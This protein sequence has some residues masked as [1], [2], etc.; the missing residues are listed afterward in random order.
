VTLY[1]GQPWEKPAWH[2]AKAASSE[3]LIV[4]YQ[5][6]VVMP[7]ALGLLS[8][9]H[10]SWE[11]ATPDVALCLGETTKAMIA[12][13][14]EPSGAK[15]V[16]FGSF[17]ARPGRGERRAPRPGL[18][19]VL[20][21]PEGIRSEAK[22]IFDFVTR[23]AELLPEHR[24]IFRCHP[25]LPFDR[26]RPLLDTSPERYTNIEVSTRDA[27]TEDFDRSSVVLYRGSSAVLYA[28]LHGLKPVYLQS[29]G[30]PDVDPLFQLDRWREWIG[31]QGQFKQLLR[32]YAAASDDDADRAWS[33]AVEYVTAYTRPVEGAAVDRFLEAVGLIP[34]A[35]V[36]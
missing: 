19:T 15:L 35:S 21:L 17:R 9:N 32:C 20:V 10:D 4:G 8:P 28:I 7:H 13:A 24:F 6:T 34:A 22:L 3:C 26:V 33:P 31:S 14:H 5:H 23:A 18:R 27:I 11:M 36:A 12:P 30:H 16:V 29:P 2:G 25:A 1:E